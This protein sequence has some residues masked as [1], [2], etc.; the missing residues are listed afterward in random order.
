MV[1]LKRYRVPVGIYDQGGVF[2][3]A[4]DGYFSC[5]TDWGNYAYWWT[6]IGDEDFRQFLITADAHYVMEK[7]NHSEMYGF[8]LE[9]T[10]KNSK[11]LI[12]ENVS[13]KETAK[14]LINELKIISSEQDFYLWW[15][16]K[17]Y[18]GDLG[19]VEYVISK[20]PT[21][22][23]QGFMENLWPRFQ[24]LLKDDIEKNPTGFGFLKPTQYPVNV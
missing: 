19:E 24:K 12:K 8:H 16:D 11:K 4:S 14:E 1:E 5:V 17:S 18:L 23:A 10:I 15:A 2:I 3:I 20:K 9:D 21:G 6:G 7:L 13:D 22:K